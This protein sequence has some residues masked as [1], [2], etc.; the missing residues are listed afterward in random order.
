MREL[1]DGQDMWRDA[2]WA[3]LIV[4]ATLHGPGPRC[5]V[6]DYIV[7][8]VCNP[9]HWHN[10][11]QWSAIPSELWITAPSLHRSAAKITTCSSWPPPIAYLWHTHWHDLNYRPQP[12]PY[13]PHL[14]SPY[15]GQCCALI[16]SVLSDAE[17]YLW[18]L[19]CS[20]RISIKTKQ[21]PT[22]DTNKDG[23]L[24]FKH[25]TCYTML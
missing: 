10:V 19:I 1:G 11:V 8:Q 23:L 2:C 17:H 22:T 9:G 6:A 3:K 16:P 25:T 7:I 24:C 15:I 14:P 12:S 4:V 21:F 5:W 20:S 13:Q 18:S